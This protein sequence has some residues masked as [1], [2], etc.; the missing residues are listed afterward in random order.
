[1]TS[2]TTTTNTLPPLPLPEGISSNYVSCPIIGL[3]IH[4]LEAG[5]SPTTAKPLI[6]LLHGYPELG[7]S[8]RKIMPALAAAGYH[9]VAPDQRGYGRSDAP[10]AVDDYTILH[11]VGDAVESRIADTLR[12]LENRL[13]AEPYIV[14]AVLTFTSQWLFDR[15][16]FGRPLA[17]CTIAAGIVL[18]RTSTMIGAASEPSLA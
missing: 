2:Q 4:Y 10:A 15:H 16:S 18:G 7:F 5:Y 12:D 11:L 13:Q 9:V 1:M 14:D 6:L 17:S 8:W 3:N